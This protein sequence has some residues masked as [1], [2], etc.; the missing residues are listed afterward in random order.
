MQHAG[1]VSSFEAK[2]RILASAGQTLIAI[3]EYSSAADIFEAGAAGTQNPAAVAS[4]VQMFRKTKRSE[5]LPA[6]E[7][8]EP[9]DLVRV[10]LARAMKLDL[11]EKDLIELFS[12]F[13]LDAQD[14]GAMR[15]FRRGLVLGMAKMQDSGLTMETALDLSQ[16]ILQFSREGSDETGW[17]IHVS[18]PGSG[19]A[20]SQNQPLFVIKENGKYRLLGAAGANDGIARFVL[21]LVEQGQIE[22]AK[23]WLDRLR[24]EQAAGS[25]DDPLDGP[26][27]AR[28]W[29]Q[30][31][32]ADSRAVRVAAATLLATTKK[33]SG[34]A[35]T[36]LEDA[37]QDANDTVANVILAALTDAYFTSG[38]YA[39]SLTA[40]SAS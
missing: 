16:S 15:D 40:A 39:N 18:Y 9:E 2:Q 29:L 20:N 35:T 33:S 13:L 4:V 37:L 10:F 38:Q 24:Q 25:G 34:I 14:P 8:K 19:T 31:Q 1:E 32:A 21:K 27:F 11:P 36:I 22:R 3:R 6:F 26:L 5:N 7:V 28:I 23:T 30:G 12:P 17:V